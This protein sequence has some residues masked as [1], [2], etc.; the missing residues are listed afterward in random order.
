MKSILL[1]P[2]WCTKSK[3]PMCLIASWMFYLV[4]CDFSRNIFIKV[5]PS[6]QFSYRRTEI[7][8]SLLRSWFP[9]TKHLTYDLHITDLQI[10]EI[11]ECNQL[12]KMLNKI[13]I[14]FKLSQDIYLSNSNKIEEFAI[15]VEVFCKFFL[16]KFIA[17]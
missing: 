16:L 9:N 2:F 15:G 3:C 10:H 17:I 12:Y 1:L 14:D 11:N 4:V 8:D 7:L 13:I 6:T 5:L